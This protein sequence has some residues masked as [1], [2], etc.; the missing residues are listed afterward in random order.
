MKNHMA[1]RQRFESKLLG[2]FSWVFTVLALFALCGAATETIDIGAGAGTALAS[3]PFA[4]F[5]RGPLMDKEPEGGGGGAAAAEK[6]FQKQAL[7]GIKSV[8][9]RQDEIKD[10]LATLDKEGKKLSE[11]FSKHVKEFEGLPGQVR[12]IEL[13]MKKIGLKVAREHRSSYT[14]A[15]EMIRLN[16]EL[17]EAVNAIVRGNAAAQQ[18]AP[19][20]KMNDGQKKAYDNYKRALGEDSSPGSTYINDDLYTAIYSLIAEY[21]VWRNFDVIAAGTKTTKLIVDQTDPVMGFVG[22]GVAP[23]EASYTGTSVSATV[24]KMLAWI[25]ISNELLED[26]EVDVTGH[27]LPKFARATA[28][29][30][31]FIGLAADGTDD[32][33]NGAYTGIFEGGTAAVAAGGNTTTATLD[34]D[35]VLNTMLAANAAVLDR[36]NC[37]F[38]HPQMLIRLLK[39]KDG[40]GRPIFLPSIDAPSPGAIGSILGAPVKLAHAAPNEDAASKAI[41]AFGD[42][43]AMAILLRKDLEFAASDQAKFTEDKTVFRARARA[44]AKLR[45][46]DGI[47]VLTTAAS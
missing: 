19:A 46:A 2:M 30:M 7:A 43:M 15:L 10:N 3:L 42:P 37:W 21:G 16:G 29:R 22:E 39:I 12:D 41:A 11:D 4:G 5:L 47:S 38:I 9:D 27:V 31:D 36:P 26:S 33:T 34:F 23:S 32:A 25:G 40:N 18:G 45:Q 28:L 17:N 6:D 1:K 8:G 44:A 20:V 35:D 14:S 13:D 24:K